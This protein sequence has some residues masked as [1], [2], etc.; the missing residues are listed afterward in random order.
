M[1]RFFYPE[2]VAVIGVSDT[3][4]N[5]G[6]NIIINLKNFG[7]KGKCY[8]V[9]ID[10]GT[11]CGQPI[12]L[13]VMDIQDNPDL[14]VVFVK[15]KD[16]PAMADACGRKG[17]R[18]IVVPSAGFSEC[19]AEHKALENELLAV[20]MQ[21]DMRMIGPNCMGIANLENGLMLP[22]GL[23]E[24]ERFV[25]GPVGIVSQSGN[26]AVNYSQV[27]SHEKIGVS[28][29]ASIGNKLDVDEVDLLEYYLKD[30]HTEIIFL[31][32][33]SFSRGRDFLKLAATSD[34]PILV[35]KT[36]IGDTSR[37]IALSHTNAMASD[38][39]VVEA[40]FRQVGVIRVHDL[41]E[42]VNA[43]K[44]LLLPR[45]KGNRLVCIASSGGKALMTADECHRHNFSLPELPRQ[46]IQGLQKYARA[47]VINLTNPLDFGDLFDMEIYVRLM[48]A[49]LKFPDVDAIFYVLGYSEAWSALLDYQKVFNF[50]A[51]ANKTSKKPVI[52][53]LDCDYPP[54]LERLCATLPMPVFRSIPDVFKAMRQVVNQQNQ[55]RRN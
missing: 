38:E 31:Y 14:A 5:F 35:Q 24:P 36:N 12:Y 48:E 28:K 21:Y 47:R 55:K 16:V 43:A 34:K 45:L 25:P 20:C 7:F 13:S 46:V 51:E 30:P 26:V 15:A 27:L 32:L 2:S 52:V 40:V 18:R 22:F 1:D 19:L 17:I 9:G 39:R 10:N 37:Q 8:A 42:L 11:V 53:C 50:C 49:L 41:N 29:V 23:Y 4:S 44:I 33:E 54:E 6:K 3:A